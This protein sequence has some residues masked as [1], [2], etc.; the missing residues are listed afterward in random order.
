MGDR[1]K[2]P[3]G[4]TRTKASLLPMLLHRRLDLLTEVI[5]CCPWLQTGRRGDDLL[6]K[7]SGWPLPDGESTPKEVIGVF[8]TDRPPGH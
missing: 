4:P 3:V 8:K 6:R 2:R 1:R 7:R 5:C